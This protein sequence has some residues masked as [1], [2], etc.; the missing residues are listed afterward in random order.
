[1][2]TPLLLCVR[3]LIS[4]SV[5]LF[6]LFGYIG[7]YVI[8]H[9][10]IPLLLRCPLFSLFAHSIRFGTLTAHSHTTT[11]THLSCS[12]SLHAA[13]LFP[14]FALA[15]SPSALLP[16]RSSP[17]PL[18]TC[19]LLSLLNL[20]CVIWFDHLRGVCSLVL[21]FACKIVASLLAKVSSQIQVLLVFVFSLSLCVF[22]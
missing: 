20:F 8:A 14:L 22:V 4:L 3:A 2:S 16:L 13:L 21:L 10:P 1:M 11:Y 15:L 7:L 6:L 9:S 19:F 18:M 17:G 12:R 5:V